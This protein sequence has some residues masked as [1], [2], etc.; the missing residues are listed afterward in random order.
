[1][2]TKKQRRVLNFIIDF[3][4]KSGHS[5]SYRDIMKKMKYASVASVALHINSLVAKG[6]L[7]K[8]D[9]SAYS[10]EVIKH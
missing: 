1:M 8:K 2:L 9:R 5:P 3:T 7:K 4:E 10:I 6:Y